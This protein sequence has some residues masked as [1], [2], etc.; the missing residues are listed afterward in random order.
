MT[1]PVSYRSEKSPHHHHVEWIELKGD[2]NLHECAVMKRDAI[3][4]VLFFKLNDLDEIDKRRFAGIVSSRN[5]S[6]LELWDLMRET[7]LRNGVN[8]LT[9]FNQLVKQ[10]T[11]NGQIIDPKQGQIGGVYT[12]Q[13]GQVKA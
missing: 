5:A 13:N 1:V 2:G 7:T 11:P 10:L 8:A 4:N 9:Y 3:G 12:P 6:R